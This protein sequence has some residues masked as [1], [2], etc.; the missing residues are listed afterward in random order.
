MGEDVEAGSDD[1]ALGPVVECVKG[2]ITCHKSMIGGDNIMLLLCG[3]EC[4]R[5]T[6]EQNGCKE[7][8]RVSQ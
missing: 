3:N 8:E 2:T 1:E 4:G 6:Q 5:G 7:H